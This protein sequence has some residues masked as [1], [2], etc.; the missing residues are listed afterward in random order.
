MK[1]KNTKRWGALTRLPVPVLCAAAAAVLWLA[2]G[3]GLLL[4]DTVCGAVGRITP[5]TVTLSDTALY[6]LDQLEA[7]DAD[8][9]RSTEGDP[10]LFLNPGQPVRT[11]RLVA[12]YSAEGSEMDLYYHLPGRGYDPNLRL[13]PTLTA[14]GE[15]TYTLPFYA[16]QGL[17]LD[18]CDRIGVEVTITEIRLNEPQ[19]WYSYYVPS[20]WQLFWLAAGAG[21][22]A[23]T[24]ETCR[25]LFPNRKN[26]TR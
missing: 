21:L 14:P 13:W 3:A 4:F 23:C 15:Y 7:V 2:W 9:L 26:K 18:L 19:P 6:T 12:Q 10:K 8:T 20:L 16:G 11:V 5:Q 25:E 22:A 1:H 17:R 24:I